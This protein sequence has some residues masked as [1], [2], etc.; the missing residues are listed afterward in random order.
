L[1]SLIEYVNKKPRKKYFPNHFGY[2]KVLFRG[3]RLSI[4]SFFMFLNYSRG[5]F[6]L[7]AFPIVAKYSIF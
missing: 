5:D 3:Q 2:F 7:S 6:P 1:V 4:T